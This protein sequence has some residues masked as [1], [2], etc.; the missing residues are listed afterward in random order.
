[1]KRKN[2][3]TELGLV[4][5]LG[6]AFRPRNSI[7]Y[8]G[9]GDDTAVMRISKQRYLLITADMLIE[10]KHFASGD[11]LSDVGYKALACSI[12]DIAAMGGKPFAAVVSVGLPRRMTMHKVKD[13]YR[14]VKK[15]ADK[16]FVDIIGGDTNASDKFVVDVAMLGFVQPRRLVLRSGARAGDY[17]FVTGALGGSQRGR[18][19]R[20]LPRVNEAQWLT[21]QYKLNAMIDISDGLVLDLYRIIDASKAGAVIFENLIPVH[22]DAKNINDALYT[23]EDFELLFTMGEHDSRKLLE[24]IEKKRVGFPIACIGKII[25]EKSTLYYVDRHDRACRK[26]QRKGFTHF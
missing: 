5:Y 9:I 13:F 11:A 8:R 12:S 3:I 6:Y 4:N 2:T 1:M 15:A 25:D 14:G 19:L 21:S 26:L 20:F 18:H 24:R 17:I 23:G 22:P 10:N 7:V 16:F